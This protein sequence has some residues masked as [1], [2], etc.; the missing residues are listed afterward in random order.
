VTVIA[1]TGH[2]RPVHSDPSGADPTPPPV[3]GTVALLLAAGA[4]SRFAGPTH[5]L[6]APLADRTVVDHAV[7][8]ALR[9]GI[10]PVLVVTGAVRPPL[11]E[12]AI[13]VPHPDWADGQATSLQRGIAAARALGASAVVVGLADQPGIEPASWAAV[14]RSNAPIAV[15]T[16]DGR[17]GNPVRLHAHVWPLLP[18]TGDEGARRLIRDRPD[19]VE[20]V[21]CRGSATDIDTVEDLHRWQS[22][23]ST[24]SP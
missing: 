12:G 2:D 14:A 15:A 7:D 21:P 11:P 6:L 19:L 20:P 22:N 4:G 8:A 23:S 1:S 16:Y 17:R 5:K 10:G 3:T 13:E 18:R 24:N 9:A